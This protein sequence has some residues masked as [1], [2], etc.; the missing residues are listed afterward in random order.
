MEVTRM[1]AYNVTTK[2][3]LVDSNDAR[4]DTTSGS[5][6]KAISD[7]LESVDSSKTI[8]N[9]SVAQVSNTTVMVLIVHDS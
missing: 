1:A 4:A 2:V 9:I 8:R 7:Y 6:A 3:L 5:T